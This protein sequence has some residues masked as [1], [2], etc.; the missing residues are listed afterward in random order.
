MAAGPAAGVCR[1]YG[2]WCSGAVAEPMHGPVD[3]T[4]SRMRYT[5]NY[6]IT[7]YNTQYN[8]TS[9]STIYYIHN[10]TYT[11]TRY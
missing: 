7:I 6:N 5:T 11:N 1:V 9:T 10:S 8:N 3:T 4:T 2:K